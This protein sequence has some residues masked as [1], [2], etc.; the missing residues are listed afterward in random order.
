MGAGQVQSRPW[1]LTLGVLVLMVSGLVLSAS[2]A[3]ASLGEELVRFGSHGSDA[4][5]FKLGEGGG[6]ATDPESGHVFVSDIGNHRISEFTAW[7]EFVKAWGWGVDDGSAGA[8]QVCATSCFQGSEGSGVGQLNSPNG[9]AVG[10]N[11]QI[12]VFEKLNSRVQVFDQSGAFVRMF[13]GGVNQTTG[14]D[15]CT[16]EDVKK[17]DVCGGGET[18][19]GPSEFSLEP[20]GTW[21]DYL[22]VAADGTVYVGDHNRIQKFE[23]GGT[24]I[25]S[26]PLPEVGDPGALTIDPASGDIY[27][28]MALTFPFSGAKAF[29]LDGTTGA[30]EYEL[31]TTAVSGIDAIPG[32]TVYV[33]D[34]PAPAS[35]TELEKSSRLR[36]ISPEGDVVESCCLAGVKA[37]LMALETNVV[38]EAGGV[39][40]Y[41]AHWEFTPEGEE[42]SFIEVR[43]PGSDKWLPPEVP[44]T[45]EDQFA[46]SVGDEAAT[47]K[48]RINPNFWADTSYYVEYG[49]TPCSEGGCQST[50]TPPGTSLDSG[51]IKKP[52]ATKGV[53]LSGLQSDTTYYFRFVSE[54]GGGG[55]VFG[56]DP[57]GAGPQ[58]PTFEDGLES[59][60]TTFG[61][62]SAPTG[63]CP[64]EEFRIGPSA[65]LEECRAYEM[66]SPVD[67]L[68]GDILVG[69]NLND[70]PAR[71]NQ[72]APGGEQITYSSY[73]AFGDAESAG[74]T[75]QYL[76]SRG[77]GG[78][79]SHA[80][81][82]PREGRVFSGT[83]TLDTQYKG[84]LEDLSSGWIVFDSAP[85]LD[86]GAVPDYPNL[87][88]RDNASDSYEALTT[89]K[90]ANATEYNIELQGFSADGKHT[91]F[92]ANAK[93]TPNASANLVYQ[94]YESTEGS[95]KLVSIR[96]SGTVNPVDSSVGSRG[97]GLNNGREAN[98][99]HAVSDDGAR[100]YWS[101]IGGS[102]RVYV[103]VNGTETVAVSGG[104]ATFWSAKP[105]G[106]QAIYTE[107][108]ALKRFELGPKSSSILAAEGVQGVMGASEDLS[109]I[110][111]VSTAALEGKGSPGKRN[112][113]L[114]EEGQ[115]LV[116]VGALSQ[117][118]S[119]LSPIALSPRKRVARVTADGSVA[120]FMS[121]APLTGADNIDR[122]SGAADAEV[123]R[124]EAAT[125]ELRCLSCNYTGA[126]P[127]GREL[128]LDAALTGYWYASRIPTWE[129]QHHAPRVISAD[130]E[131][132]FFDSFNPLVVTDTDESQDVY[133]WEAPG[134]GD[135][136]LLSPT[137]VDGA[138]GCINLISGGDE[139]QDAEFVDASADGR[140]V[141]F[142]TGSS[143]VA[144]DPGQIDLYDAREGGG[145]A[146][147]PPIPP[148]CEGEACQ[149]SSQPPAPPAPNGS[150]G[151]AVGGNVVPPKPCRKGFVRK[152]GKCVKR[153]KPRPHKRNKQQ[154]RGGKRR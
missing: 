30:E 129:L 80:I 26:L 131:R 135:C 18:G 17:G 64:N 112:L 133:E 1:G 143:L 56:V 43:G 29:R 59:T 13:G 45:V 15:V 123:F 134:K 85:L 87:Y 124:Y 25:A 19:A 58:E 90:P 14:A 149:P 144:D 12:Y 142:L 141:F 71:L 39:G 8:L 44:P 145:F 24:Y 118:D 47:V 95:L 2:P 106:S 82:P 23:A 68:G 40:L 75:T 126:R 42:I 116:L 115:P 62:A 147:S 83:R 113:Y 86:D 51:V 76:A 4:G 61:P 60:F 154:R 65:L 20:E 32:G 139:E 88:R 101:E 122:E 104:S 37:K 120:V 146:P 136:S 151:V 99:G 70:T 91:V 22:D 114:Y 53:E 150:E 77:A 81:S 16:A 36:E 41:V 35:E 79:S 31:P 6:I 148:A 9:I 140:D 138:G 127:S 54:S 153:H 3:R 130:G 107:A 34:D 66:V 7:G 103:R 28:A 84:F 109:R 21:G 98:V 94:T 89:S 96:P 125:G 102:N 117:S 137:Y 105:D 38:T 27:L 67:K 46:A 57:D 100:I 69:G 63:P 5:E 72:A 49:T 11:D 52:I 48:A 121:R 78:W 92:R 110:Y 132:V 152:R 55:P 74:Y 111:F 119:T 73:R 10:P 33:A 93:L 97:L 108:G 50:E 128:E